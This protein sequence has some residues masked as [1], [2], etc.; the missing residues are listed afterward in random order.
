MEEQQMQPSEKLLKGLRLLKLVKAARVMGFWRRAQQ[1]RGKYL[2]TLFLEFFSIMLLGAHLSACLWG[3]L[4]HCRSASGTGGARNASLPEGANTPRGAGGGGACTDN[5]EE[6]AVRRCL[7]T[8][9]PSRASAA[10]TRDV[11][12]ITSAVAMHGLR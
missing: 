7:S 6:D 2:E 1:L 4:L 10:K 12:A 11:V 8:P 9:K 3:L 5:D